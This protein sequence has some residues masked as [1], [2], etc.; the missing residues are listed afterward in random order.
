MLN[1]LN[2]AYDAKLS[3]SMKFLFLQGA[4][5]SFVNSVPESIRK[6]SNKS[7]DSTPSKK[8]TNTNKFGGKSEYLF[9]A[10]TN[11]DLSQFCLKRQRVVWQYR[12]AHNYKINCMKATH[13]GEF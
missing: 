12:D 10:D 5:N 9:I 2:N 4:N 11:G 1:K 8:E 3:A 7:Q 6:L 13:D